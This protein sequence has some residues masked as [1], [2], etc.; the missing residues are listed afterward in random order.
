MRDFVKAGRE[1]VFYGNSSEV[2]PLPNL[3]EV[4]K[5][6][7]R[8]FL[9]EGLREVFNEVFPIE[10]YKGDM[11]LEFVDYYLGEPKCTEF[12]AKEKDLSYQAPLFAK[13][14]LVSRLTGEVKEE[15]VYMGD[16]PI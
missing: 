15:D 2:L 10:G 14:R 7:F 11:V 5:N 1:R 16:L 13:L 9:E 3:I 8:W 4:Q 6:S 12:E